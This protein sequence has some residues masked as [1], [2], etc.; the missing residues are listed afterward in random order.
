MSWFTVE[1]VSV[2]VSVLFGLAGI[3]FGLWQY[4]AQHRATQQAR[5]ES[6]EPMVIADITTTEND[7]DVLIFVVENIGPSI[8]RNVRLVADPPPIRSFDGPDQ[9]PMHEWQV[10]ARGIATLTPRRR[11]V[12]FF[13][14]G[15]RRFDTGLPTQYTFTVTAEGPF[16]AAP[17]LVYDVDLAPLRD[18]WVGQTTLGSVV[19]ALETINGQLGEVSNEISNLSVVA[20]QADWM[21]EPNLAHTSSPL[22][23]AQEPRS[24]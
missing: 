10:F 9:V 7:R 15:S 19:K 24:D 14:L 11:M 1:R 21:M 5:R 20:R 2:L 6:L 18:A 22:T 17:T 13:D 23:P 3:G 8:A 4:Y 16:G 12:Y